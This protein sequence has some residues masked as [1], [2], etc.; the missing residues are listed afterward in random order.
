[1]PLE[2]SQVYQV[3]IPSDLKVMLEF[4]RCLGISHYKV[5]TSLE[6]LEQNQNEVQIYKRTRHSPERQV[7]FFNRD[8]LEAGEIAEIKRYFINVYSLFQSS[9]P[10]ENLG[11]NRVEYMI[12]AHQAEFDAGAFDYDFTIENNGRIEYTFD[13]EREGLVHFTWGNI[14][15]SDNSHNYAG[16]R[17]KDVEY[18]FGLVKYT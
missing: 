15:Y 4:S 17:P 18:T 7:T 12:T 9:N 13:K 10:D 14:L 16:K 2:S 3:D 5:F 11:T 1:M 8:G 6:D